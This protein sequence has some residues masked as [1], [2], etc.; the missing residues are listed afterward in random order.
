MRDNS[1][2]SRSARKLDAASAA[3]DSISRLPNGK[4]GALGDSTLSSVAEL[5]RPETRESYHTRKHGDS[6]L[7]G[8]FQQYSAGVGQN[9]TPDSSSSFLPVA[10]ASSAASEIRP[11]DH[12]NQMIEQLT[13]SM[14]E[15]QKPTANKSPV[16]AAQPTPQP[17]A[18]APLPSH[19]DY[20]I[21]RELSRSDS[22]V[23]YEAY[24]RSLRRYV[25]I[26]QLNEQLRADPRQSELFWH[27]ARFLASLVHENVC[28]VYSVDE[29]QAWI[30]M[31]MMNGS[32]DQRLAEG[33]LPSDLVRSILRQAL[34]G[35]KYLHEQGKLHG[36]IKP[37]KLLLD[38][39]CIKLSA[40][41]GFSIGGEFRRPSG[42]QKYVAPELLRPE[43]FGDVGPGVDLYCLG[44]TAL[45]LL[46]GDNF[47]TA[48]KGVQDVSDDLA[49]MRW[50]CSP[51]E[52]LPELEQ[53][54]P[55]LPQDL[56]KTLSRMLAKPVSAR[57]D[58][59]EAALK[60]LEEKPI[61]LVDVPQ[62]ADTNTR[63]EHN[64]APVQIGARP[65][66]SA[67]PWPRQDQ[68]S[69]NKTWAAR[70]AQLSDPEFLNKQSKNPKVLYPVL[71]VIV[72]LMFPLLMTSSSGK[73]RSDNT[74]AVALKSTPAGAQV[75]LDG[76]PLGI[77][78]P[79]KIELK[80][81]TYKIRAEM[82]GF[83][84]TEKTI[85]VE[86]SG[87]D[88][89]L[90]FELAA[91]PKKTPVK[92]S[93][94]KKPK[95][96]LPQEDKPKVLVKA[97]VQPPV[98]SQ[99]P[100][101][102]EPQPETRTFQREVAADFATYAPQLIRDRNDRDVY[103]S[104]VHGI[105]NDAWE[106]KN[107][108]EACEI[109]DGHFRAARNINRHAPWVYYAHGLLL[110]KN[111]RSREALTQFEI[112]A[113]QSLKHRIPLFAPLRE[114]IRHRAL[115][116]EFAPA[117]RDSLHLAQAVISFADADE[118]GDQATATIETNVDFVG[119]IMGFIKGPAENKA[120]TSV[121][122]AAWEGEL[123]AALPSHSWITYTEARDGVLKKY[124]DQLAFKELKERAFNERVQAE[125]TS[126]ETR[127]VQ[128]A[129]N[130][131][132]ERSRERSHSRTSTS[133][134][135]IPIGQEQSPTTTGQTSLEQNGVGSQQSTTL[136]Q[137]NREDP[138]IWTNVLTKS[139]RMVDW[140][141]QYE[142]TKHLDQS[143]PQIRE[144]YVLRTYLPEDFELRRL[145]FISD[146]S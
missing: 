39:G 38:D 123:Q 49:W 46:M 100:V 77:A 6:S 84:P 18:G 8:Q 115:N 61:I 36:E 127:A 90:H 119:R 26:K 108:R 93:A 22:A 138:S 51:S 111:N 29:Q 56:A 15:T 14:K 112:S 118:L 17:A 52:T 11:I 120:R 25:A 53:L 121:D 98:E 57:Y 5:L 135:L 37:S 141:R 134:M 43:V 129:G 63:R 58:S 47:S 97:D 28:R 21:L 126:G 64:P 139:R 68:A 76:K 60:D 74:V 23:V 144:P 145:V 55:K 66:L 92:P 105:L 13:R 116:D 41:A 102:P 122:L 54:I 131:H 86:S 31:E 80:Q 16:A 27:E 114:V 62:A 19:V 104:H 109:A 137:T 146:L 72:L 101:A 88:L 113:E 7:N 70:F 79:G 30:V 117:V 128:F 103:L 69:K 24:D 1:K 95:T 75:L 12:A 65:N 107:F 33:P 3:D 32:L 110:S 140:T 81:G 106:T 132:G 2:S 91:L 78:A 42:T 4:S 71:A 10:T 73:K 94:P 59:A 99:P 83:A 20:E 124:T 136:Q 44:L 82:A 87:E 48:F 45:E 40:S 89:R 96:N 85:K 50:H 130:L 133:L 125:R 67:T 34:Q 9:D 143:Q 35:L 142:S